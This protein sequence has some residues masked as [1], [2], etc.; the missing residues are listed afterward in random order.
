MKLIKSFLKIGL[1]SFALFFVFF[2][3]VVEAQVDQRCMTKS[4]CEERRSDAEKPSDGFYTEGEATS[5]GKMYN[6]DTGKRQ[7]A[8]FCLPPGKATTEISFGGKDEFKNFPQF[9]KYMYEW[10]FVAA[11]VL[12]VLMVIIAGIEYMMSMG[13]SSRVKAAKNKAAGAISGIILLAGSYVILSTLNPALVNLRLPSI[14]LIREQNVS[15]LYCS[16]IEGKEKK[17]FA[18]VS[19]DSSSAKEALENNPKEYKNL[20]CGEDYY[21]RDS[22]GT[23]KGLKC[24][25]GDICIGNTKDNE[26]S[27]ESGMLGGNITGGNDFTVEEGEKF[28]HKIKLMAVCSSGKI[29][30]TNNITPSAIGSN[31]KQTYMAKGA[32]VGFYDNKCNNSDRDKLLGFYL[33][34]QIND[35]PDNLLRLAGRKAIGENFLTENPGGDQDHDWWALGKRRKNSNTCN[36]NLGKQLI[37]QNEKDCIHPA[38]SAIACSCGAVTKTLNDSKSNREKLKPYLLSKKELKNGF[39]CNINLSRKNF[40]PMANTGS[41]LDNWGSYIGAGV[42]GGACAAGAYFSGG[43]GA[44][45]CGQLV[46]AGATVGNLTQRAFEGDPSACITDT[47]WPNED[48]IIPA[49]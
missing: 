20:E 7:E 6:P 3:S 42:G 49:Q 23:C 17:T 32:V 9:I 38:K 48:E 27:C 26:Q 21:I 36:L 25:S 41:S 37:S 22:A 31:K 40:I 2:P 11:S 46:G 16:N 28:V 18:L 19:K 43:L 47:F 24:P 4:K 12:A 15:P 13:N 14:W 5:C 1:A 34:A 29:F 30:N 33:G 35:P 44:S 10:S 45:I 8:G 39:T